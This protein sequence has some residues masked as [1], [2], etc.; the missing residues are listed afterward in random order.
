M[1]RS[2]AAVA[3]ALL[4]VLALLPLAAAPVAAGN[5]KD[6]A[7]AEHATDHQVLDRGADRQRQA[8]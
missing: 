2:K 1:R 6:K 4:T 7:K 8:P 5:A 3:A